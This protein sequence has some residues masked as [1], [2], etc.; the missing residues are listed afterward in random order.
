MEHIKRW[1]FTGQ[2]WVGFF[3]KHRTQGTRI[4]IPYHSKT[5]NEGIQERNLTKNTKKA[6]KNKSKKETNG[7]FCGL[8][9][10]TKMT[11]LEK[12]YSSVGYWEY[13]GSCF[14]SW[15]TIISRKHQGIKGSTITVEAVKSL[16]KNNGFVSYIMTSIEDCDDQESIEKFQGDLRQILNERRKLHGDI[17]AAITDGNNGHQQVAKT[18]NN[19]GPV[20]KENNIEQQ[21]KSPVDR[22]TSGI[23][24]G[25]GGVD[26][27]IRIDQ[28]NSAGD[29]ANMEKIATAAQLCNEANTS[30]DM[31]S[32]DAGFKA[33]VD[34]PEASVMGQE[35]ANEDRTGATLQIG[36]ANN[37]AA[38]R[39]SAKAG[40]DRVTTAKYHA[41]IAV[42]GQSEKSN[43]IGSTLETNVA[44]N[45]AGVALDAG[46]T[47]ATIAVE[48]P[49]DLRGTTVQK[50]VQELEGE[51]AGMGGNSMVKRAGHALKAVHNTNAAGWSVMHR[52]NASQNKR[53]APVHTNQVNTPKEVSTSKSFGVLVRES[54][55]DDTR[56][57][58]QQL[59]RE[60][61]PK[62]SHSKT[63]HSV[64]QNKK[65]E[66]TAAPLNVSKDMVI[67]NN[68]KAV[69]VTGALALEE[70]V[71]INSTTLKDLHS[72]QQIVPVSS[73]TKQDRPNDNLVKNMGVRRNVSTGN[74]G[75]VLSGSKDQ[76]GATS[77]IVVKRK[78]W[79]ERVEEEEEDYTDSPNAPTFVPSKQQQI[80]A[81]LEGVS[82]TIQADKEV[83]KS[84]Q[85]RA[86][87]ATVLSS[88]QNIDATGSSSAM[89]TK[90][91]I[92]DQDRALLDTLD[93]PKPHRYAYSNGSKTTSQKMKVS[94][95]KGHEPCS[96][97]RMKRHE[98][99]WMVIQEEANKKLEANLRFPIS[100]EATEDTFATGQI[101]KNIDKTKLGG[102]LWCNQ[103]EEFSEEGEDHLDDESNRGENEGSD[104]Q[105]GEE[106]E[107]SVN[108]K[109]F[110]KQLIPSN[111]EALKQ[112]DGIGDIDNIAGGSKCKLIPMV[113]TPK[114]HKVLELDKRGNGGQ[115]TMTMLDP[116][117]DVT[118]CSPVVNE[119]QGKNSTLNKNDL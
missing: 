95:A 68:P 35:K 83:A 33:I 61:T 7:Q 54:V 116:Q 39:D 117:T 99:L 112:L 25:R 31:Q 84:G 4:T 57:R 92:S 85:Q 69:E 20:L 23:N 26:A 74:L 66:A 113:A 70:D 38:A 49:E 88:M 64:K 80:V 5:N 19:R 58:V 9:W 24:L 86:I 115:E 119:L 45:A 60:A 8:R 102:R 30:V 97:K 65:S 47:K 81:A 14:S 104:D 71:E 10:A 87:S 13:N 27:G 98:P 22:A 46:V 62:T 29:R 2:F 63:P 40:F 36:K 59:E 78:T 52:Q 18:G 105:Q 111:V 82:S 51:D 72:S 91:L 107:Q 77:A 48:K 3:D 96:A 44:L 103:T 90:A 101:D 11:K 34:R 73:S 89:A 67:V 17:D 32:T 100:D 93:S 110:D 118:L 50:E 76:Q 1:Q 12:S 94:V 108:G 43:L 6:G 42:V 37:P 53:N 41:A 28:L 109:N 15:T 55:M 79:A 75:E 16:D 114:V 56:K 21:L 106:E